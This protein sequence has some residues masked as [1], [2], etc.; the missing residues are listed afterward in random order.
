MEKPSTEA[1]RR[2]RFGLRTKGRTAMTMLA[3]V[4]LGLGVS[5]LSISSASAAAATHLSVSASS[6]QTVG[7]SFSVTVQALDSTNSVDTTNTDTVHFTS[8][9]GSA[10]LPA[11]AALVA[12]QRTFSVTLNTTGT[13]SITVNDVTNGSVAADST[14]VTVNSTNN[15]THFLVSAPSSV[16]CG[17]SFSFTV[18]ALT[19]SN[20]QANYSGTIDFSSSDSDASLPGSQSLG[21][22]VATYSATLY[23]AGNQTITVSDGSISGSD[24]VD[25]LSSCNNQGNAVGFVVSAPSSVY[26]GSAFSFTVTAVLSNGTV[27]TGY[28]GTVHFTSS[29][30]YA[31]FSGN[32]TLSGGYGTA[33][34]ALNTVGNQSIIATDTSSGIS[35]STVVVVYATTTPTPTRPRLRL[36]PHR[37]SSRSSR[38]LR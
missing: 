17:E 13:Q 22:G 18:Q 34:A 9:D 33:T 19:S 10:V 6:P 23:T 20:S 32:M 12:G 27:A 36:L 31:S 7:Q 35:G 14:N 30:A 37:W 29:D 4:A 2:G 5:L 25:V 1:P 3:V 11:D 26:E 38:R 8:S 21:S 16:D 24:T 15:A 28:D